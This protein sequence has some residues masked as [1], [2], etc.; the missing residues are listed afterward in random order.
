MLLEEIDVLV[1][2]EKLKFKENKII[3]SDELN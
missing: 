3:L 2:K 1:N